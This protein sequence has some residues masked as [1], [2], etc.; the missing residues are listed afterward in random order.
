[1][2]VYRAA[3]AAG[4]ER[5]FVVVCLGVR[6]GADVARVG[7][8]ARHCPTKNWR[9]MGGLEVARQAAM[10]PAPG[11]GVVSPQIRTCASLESFCCVSDTECL[12]PVVLIRGVEREAM[13][14][15][16]IAQ[17]KPEPAGALKIA[18]LLALNSF[19]E[20]PRDS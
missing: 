20:L 10:L 12:R 4:S 3:L 15:V 16:F 14:P 5:G 17:P 19:G 9:S 18:V 13:H 2:V 1:L 8:Q 6:G 11:K 7:R